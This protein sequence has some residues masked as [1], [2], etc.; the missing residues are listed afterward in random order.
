MLCGVTRGRNNQYNS[1]GGSPL[2]IQVIIQNS[3]LQMEV[4]S[5]AC[6]SII[7]EGMYLKIFSHI[8]L[9]NIVTNFV[10]V[11]GEK[12]KVLGKLLVNV[13]PCDNA[14]DK[15]VQL[16][17]FVIKSKKSCVPLLGRVWLD[18]LYPGWRDVLWANQINKVSSNSLLD[19]IAVKYPSIICKSVKQVIKK[20]KAK[21]VLRSEA[22]PIFHKAY[23]VPLKLRDVIVKELDRFLRKGI[24]EQVSFSE[25]AS[26]KVIVPKKDGSILNLY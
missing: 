22:R 13:R 17:L 21:I 11:T 5:G 14:E 24:F 2:L 19:T 1:K 4:D 10:S 7:T 3:I 20:Y 18:K 26:P 23:T 16:E 6:A 9:V 25:W 8:L 15:V 12:V